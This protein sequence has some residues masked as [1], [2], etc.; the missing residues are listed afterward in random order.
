MRRETS[1]LIVVGVLFVAVLVAAG[2]GLSATRKTIAEPVG[3][4]TV[5]DPP[6]DGSAGQVF[7]LHS[8]PGLSVLGLRL[9]SSS[10]VVQVGF[11]VPFEC[12]AADES[13]RQVLLAD[14]LCANVPAHGEL[15]GGGTTSIGQTLAIVSIDVSKRCYE[16]LEI[17]TAWPPGT[18]TCALEVA[19]N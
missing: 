17:G 3:T 19:A 18:A 8:T 11:I 2:L 6:A 13:G 10:Y 15:S 5:L 14:G 12:I 16:A 9:R 1:I 7:G 4:G